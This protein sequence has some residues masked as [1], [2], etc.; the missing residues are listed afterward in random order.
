MNESLILRTSAPLLLWLSV[1]VSLFV[2]L[3]GHNAPGGGFAGG[4]IAG[5][6]FVLRFLAGGALQVRRSDIARPDVLIGA[7]LLLAVATA[8]APVALGDSLLESTIWKPEV[9]FVGEVK[10]V[11][12]AFF[13]LGVYFLVIGVV[14]AVLLALGAEPTDPVPEEGEL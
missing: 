5:C 2:L 13:D 7:G 1:A 10:V 9:P 6:A 14:L 11:S 12:S 8:L 3:R 4:L